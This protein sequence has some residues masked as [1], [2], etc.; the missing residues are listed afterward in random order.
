MGKAE[1]I[2]YGAVRHTV[3]EI[4][5]RTKEHEMPTDFFHATLFTATEHKR[6]E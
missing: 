4:A 3:I 1:H 2:R 6:E 5:Q